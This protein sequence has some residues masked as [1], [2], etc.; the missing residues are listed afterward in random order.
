M[1]PHLHVTESISLPTYLVVMSLVYCGALLWVVRRAQRLEVDRTR[2]L[3]IALILMIG[4]FIGAR[5]FH[6]VWEM[7]DFYLAR[8]L[9]LFKVWQGGFVFYGGALTAFVSAAW[10]LKRQGENWRRWA[11]FYAPVVAIS[12]GLGRLGCFFNGCC[13]GA[14]CDLPWSVAGRHPTPLYATGWELIT[15]ALLL[16][17]ESRRDQMP[18]V[19]VPG[20]LFMIWVLA[21]ATGRFIMEQF[22]ADDRGFM[23]LG[24]S[25]ASWISLILVILVIVDIWRQRSKISQS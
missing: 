3:D 14:A 12:Y 10:W 22:R 25:I 4:G 18:W 6:V 24:L 15:G 16:W 20:H 1:Y 2:A 9:D 7:P 13:Y 8:P 19:R 21:H 5:L 11:D 23:P 17:A